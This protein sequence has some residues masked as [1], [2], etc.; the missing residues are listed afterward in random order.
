MLIYILLVAFILLLAFTLDA[1]RIN[2]KQFCIMVGLAFILI[3]GLRSV[4]VGSDTTVYYLSFIDYKY[5]TFA[6]VLSMEKRDVAFY[7]L[8]WIIA[9]T[10]GSF[11][12]LTLATAVAFYYPIMRLIYK[13]SDDPTLSCF[14]LMAF[15]FFQFSMTGMRQTIALGFVVLFFLELHEKEMSKKRAA[16]FIVLA[17]LFH[18]SALIALFY[19]VI[20]QFSKR[21]IN[22]QFTLVLIPLVFLLRASII[23][24][25]QG[26]FMLIG[27]G[28]MELESVGGGFTTFLIY[29][30]LTIG[31]LLITSFEGEGEFGSNEMILYS[32]VATCLQAFVLVNSVFFRVAWYFALFIIILI[33]KFLE[34]GIFAKSE[35][36]IFRMLAYGA[37]LFMY[38][39]LTKG[40]ANVL[41]YEF[42][43][44]G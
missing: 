11:V 34:K 2:K 3:T 29:V 41:P 44:Q 19:P 43:W 26:I 14:I 16:L 7:I 12:V 21:R 40:S 22:A 30:V 6:H 20:K 32:V 28:M 33:P 17:I 35:L 8:E 15:N 42:F 24:S 18:R 38:F 23:N 10:T 37:I 13:Y 4:N 5:Y 27:F 25:L 1:G 9:K 39:G 36:K 31:S